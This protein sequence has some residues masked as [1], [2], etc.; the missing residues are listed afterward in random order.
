M[1]LNPRKHLLSLLRACSYSILQGC[2]IMLQWLNLRARQMPVSNWRDGRLNW[3]V[4][5]F[6]P[7]AKGKILQRCG[8]F[9]LT[10]C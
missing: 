10:N 7:A 4:S 2:G 9:G 8:V 6:L 3:A 1:F 5:S